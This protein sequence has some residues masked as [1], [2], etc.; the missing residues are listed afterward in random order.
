[1]RCEAAPQFAIWRP[2]QDGLEQTLMFSPLVIWNLG[3]FC[4]QLVAKLLE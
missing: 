3:Y 1:M 4:K 2:S